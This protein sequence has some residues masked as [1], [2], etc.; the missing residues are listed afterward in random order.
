[1]EDTD[2]DHISYRVP[3]GHLSEEFMRSPRWLRC[4][5]VAVEQGMKS[6]RFEKHSLAAETCTCRK[7]AF[8]P[9]SWSYTQPVSLER[10]RAQCYF[11]VEVVA[12][13]TISSWRDQ[14]GSMFWSPECDV[15][16]KQFID[17]TGS[18][19]SLGQ[20]PAAIDEASLQS[21]CA[22]MMLIQQVG[23]ELWSWSWSCERSPPT[24]NVRCD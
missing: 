4:P 22:V 18:S 6:R 19:R 17:S 8:H 12:S 10:S 23:L 13:E 24:G 9:R 15:T 16:V 21:R 5:A 11:H 20:T 1:M 14:A 7:A 2:Y 3:T